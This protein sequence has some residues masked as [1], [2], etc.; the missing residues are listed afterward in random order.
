[1][2]KNNLPGEAFSDRENAETY[3]QL[4]LSELIYG[5]PMGEADFMLN[6][7]QITQFFWILLINP[8]HINFSFFQR[9]FFF[10][11]NPLHRA[12]AEFFLLIMIGKQRIRSDT[13]A[14]FLCHCFLKY[15]IH[16][17]PAMD[18]RTPFPKFDS[19]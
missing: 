19:N 12:L 1:M 16:R 6:E 17:H 4:D 2:S 15:R 14:H 8:D 7:A 9:F 5:M 10:P 3:E 13:I 18:A 11:R